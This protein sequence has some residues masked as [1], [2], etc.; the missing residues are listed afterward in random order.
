MASR[1]EHNTAS[2]L[3]WSEAAGD[4]VSIMDATQAREYLI[5][6]K[7]AALSIMPASSFR[8]EMRFLL[9]PLSGSHAGVLSISR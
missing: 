3:I 6:A 2:S 9:P 7:R 4:F 5:Y 1:C 8:A